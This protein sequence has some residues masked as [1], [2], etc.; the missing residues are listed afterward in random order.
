LPT[1]DRAFRISVAPAIR[2]HAWPKLADTTNESILKNRLG[3]G[4]PEIMMHAVPI[5]TSSRDR[6]V[7]AVSREIWDIIPTPAHART[8]YPNHFPNGVMGKAVGRSGA[9]R[10]EDGAS[11]SE[12]DVLADDGGEPAMERVT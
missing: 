10:E 6:H 5:D 1:A 7:C 2:V 3:D 12:W 11:D 8:W 4:C 9:D